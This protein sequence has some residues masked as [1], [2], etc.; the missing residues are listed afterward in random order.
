ME[1]ISFHIPK[2]ELL[3]MLQEEEKQRFSIEYQEKCSLVKN[4]VNG[5][6]GIT[7]ELQENIARQFGYIDEISNLLA[8]DVMRRASQIYKDDERFQNTSVYVRENKAK[9]CK[10]QIGDTIPN[11]NIFNLQN[12]QLNL[13]NLFDET[14]YNIMICSSNT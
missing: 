5:W 11:I 9:N 4:E 13:H 14:K 3:L 1:Q 8:V 2:E 12:K 6:L 7:A 10:Y